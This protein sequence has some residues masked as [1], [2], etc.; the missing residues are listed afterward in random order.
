MTRAGRAGRALGRVIIEMCN[1]MYQNNTSKNFLQGLCN[2]LLKE[3]KKRG[4][5][6]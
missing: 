2:V 1:L 3:C 6:R 4:I 5:V